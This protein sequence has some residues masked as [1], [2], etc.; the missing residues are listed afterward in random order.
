MLCMLAVFAILVPASNAAAEVYVSFFYTP[1][2]VI[3]FMPE[4]G[5]A[6]S[7]RNFSG[8]V[9][10]SRSAT[11]TTGQVDDVTGLGPGFYRVTSN[12]KIVVM[13]GDMVTGSSSD[14][15]SYYARDV[16]GKAAG[17]ELYTYLRNT[18]ENNSPKLFVFSNHDSNTVAVRYRDEFDWQNIWTGTLAAGS[19]Q[20][21]AINSI[22]HIQITSDYPVSALVAGSD[23]YDDPGAHCVPAESSGTFYGDLF[24]TWIPGGEAYVYSYSDNTSVELLDTF[25]INPQPRAS[26]NLNEGEVGSYA[27]PFDEPFAITVTA[28]KPISLCRMYQNVGTTYGMHYMP[29]KSGTMIGTDFVI[30]ANDPIEVIAYEDGTAVEY[31][32]RNGTVHSYTLSALSHQLL[33]SATAGRLTATKAV[34]VV[35][36]STIGATYVP[37]PVT[38]LDTA[39][40]PPAVFAVRHNPPDPTV[41]DSTV[42]VTW[43]TDEPATTCM[44]YRRNGGAWII[45]LCSQ[46]YQNQHSVQID[47]SSYAADDLVEYYVWAIDKDNNTVLNDNNGQNYSFTITD[48]IPQLSVSRLSSLPPSTNDDA[49]TITLMVENNGISE[50]RNVQIRERITGMISPTTATSLSPVT[51]REF[52]LTIPVPNIAAGG[53]TVV[54]YDLIPLLYATYSTFGVNISTPSNITYGSP[55]GQTFSGD[56]SIPVTFSSST[57]LGWIRG[58]DYAIATNVSRLRSLNTAAQAGQVIEEAARLALARD[59]VVAE[60]ETTDRYAIEKL[61][62]SS[63]NGRLGYIGFGG[64]RF[65]LF[66][67]CQGVV[68]SFHMVHKCSSDDPREAPIADNIYA[69]VNTGDDFK[70]EVIVGRLPGED[71]DSLVDQIQNSLTGISNDRVVLMSGT[72]DGQSAFVNATDDVDGYLGQY[73]TH[74]KRHWKDVPDLLTRWSNFIADAPNTDLVVYRDHG[75]EWCWGNDCE[76]RTANLATLDFG[77]KHPMVWSIAC[78]TGDVREDPS[79]AEAFLERGAAVFIGATEV[80]P[81]TPNNKFARYLAKYHTMSA[82]YP[83]IGDAFKWAKRKVID[84]TIYFGSWCY[85]DVRVKQL[86]NEYNLYGDPKRYETPTTKALAVSRTEAAGEGPPPDSIELVLPDYEVTTTES[87]T[88]S[89]RFPVD[90]GGTLNEEGQPIVPIYIYRVTFGPEYKV[91]NVTLEDRGGLETE[92]G[93]NLPVASFADNG[94]RQDQARSQS[95][96]SSTFPPPEIRYDWE[97]E[98]QLDSSHVLLL[99]VYPFYYDSTTTE[100]DFYRNHAFTVNWN[101]SATTITDIE[102]F[103]E[104]FPLGEPIEGLVGIH[105]GSGSVMA[106]FE[107]DLLDESTG[108]VVASMDPRAVGLDEGTPTLDFGIPLA[109]TEPSTY[110]LRVRLTTVDELFDEATKRIRVGILSAIGEAFTVDPDPAGGFEIGDPITADAWFQNNGPNPI[111]GRAQLQVVDTATARIVAEHVE[112]AVVAPATAHNAQMI[113][114]STLATEGTYRISAVFEY[115]GISTDPMTADVFTLRSMGVALATDREVYGVGEKVV[116][117]ATCTGADGEPLQVTPTLWLALPD[118]SAVPIQLTYLSSL[119]IYSGWH[120]LAAGSPSGPYGFALTAEATGYHPGSAQH[121]F[122]VGGAPPTPGFT[123]SPLV[124]TVGEQVQFTDTTVGSPVSWA[125][126]FGD[127][128]TSTSQ[129]P[130]HTYATPGDKGVTLEVTNLFGTSWT[131]QTVTVVAAVEQIF[132]DGFETGDCGRWSLEVP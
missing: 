97:V 88:D 68:P 111:S 99:K 54:S 23:H 20:D 25:S 123:W 86:V 125:W 118:A 94:G 7:L 91:S 77:T 108:E 38:A 82:F 113:W 21:I 30:D 106:N 103:E 92:S 61:V 67:G 93:L 89:V 9:V 28:T 79:L 114:E 45:S 27:I 131:T 3:V 80:S 101:T 121:F 72:G 5:T 26:W 59:G 31:T 130:I 126:S 12:K 127:G 110:L 128:A 105:Q 48:D 14:T 109:A 75:L 85:V 78:L 34:S 13:A 112:D 44:S 107:V 42:T 53:F 102:P 1:G 96:V 132:A 100:I 60:L 36:T 62:N 51:T 83:T 35:A 4:V 29:A 50:A 39:P 63:W 18:S 129:N 43:A 10:W 84:E 116:V 46:T 6:A 22:D 2:D 73:T 33:P 32:Q 71:A 19:R 55:S 47:I 64:W 16:D 58:K 40:G 37:I 87:G 24:S 17:T 122:S 15:R 65:L 74:V 11:L 90:E 70:P 81:R 124:P 117:W 66:V 104:I 119:G 95:E 57:A 98:E 120:F 56:F 115:D 69:D 52:D 49:Y 8:T 41:N 76:V